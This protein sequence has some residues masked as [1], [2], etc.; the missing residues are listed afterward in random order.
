MWLKRCLVVLGLS[1]VL[2]C[3]SGERVQSVE[4]PKNQSK[5]VLESVAQTG[6]LNSG[7]MVVK[8]ELEQMKAT[9]AAKA[10]GL[11]KDLDQLEKMKGAAQ[12]KTKAKE[13]AAKL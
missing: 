3:G 4:P 13:M 9:D 5:T 8:E 6:I 1:V 2:G 10:E 11:L 7:I 12:I